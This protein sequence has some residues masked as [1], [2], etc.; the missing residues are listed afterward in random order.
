MHIDCCDPESSAQYHTDR[1]ELPLLQISRNAPCPCGSGKKYKLCC[2]R[3]DA[4]AP[5]TPSALEVSPGLVWQA[6]AV[7]LAIGFRDDLAARPVALLVTVGDIILSGEM[8]ARLGGEPEDVAAA[9]HDVVL[10]LAHGRGRLPGRVDVRHESVAAALGWRLEAHGVEVRRRVRLPEL[11]RAARGLVRKLEGSDGGP[12]LSRPNLWE[13]W[14]LDPAQ[15]GEIF[16]AAADFYGAA[17]WEMLGSG[18]AVPLTTPRGE[19]S[20]CV[21]GSAG[22]EFGLALYSEPA[23]FEAALTDADPSRRLAALRGRVLALTFD[24]QDRLPRPMR[25]EIATHHWPVAG[26]EAYPWL[27][28]FDT[29]GGGLAR[30][31]R[32]DLIAAL[33]ALARYAQAARSARRRPREWRDSASGVVIGPPFPEYDDDDDLDYL[34]DDADL[35]D[36]AELDDEPSLGDALPQAREWVR[37]AIASGASSPE[38]IQEFLRARTAG[39][40]QTPQPE[41]GGLSPEKAHRLL[42]S[43]WDGSGPL[44]LS[45]RLTAAEALRAPI[46]QRV[47][48]LLDYVTE[49]G[50][51]KATSAGNLKRADVK[52]LSARMD[53]A[54]RANY[55]VAAQYS[56]VV[57]EQDCF[58]LHRTRVLA[59]VGGLISLRKG[60][61]AVTRNGRALGSEVK[62]PALFEHLFRTYF[63]KYHIGYGTAYDAA[64]TLQYLAPMLLF[65]LRSEASDWRDAEELATDVLPPELLRRESHPA[66][67]YLGPGAMVRRACEDLI[68]RSLADF[69]LLDRRPEQDTVR[70]ERPPE[71]R[72]TPLF[73]RFLE[74]E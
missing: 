50:S 42:R 8:V 44:R 15:T 24:R 23:D 2:L 21:L 30:A 14:G 49:R 63:R 56:S 12:R 48:A 59:G 27:M 39:Y 25:R 62:A 74:F 53:D 18:Q 73:D 40:N 17:P 54:A 20:A 66:D 3:S 31:D 68:F 61:F 22:S 1:E 47:R 72:K 60:V 19:W 64:E 6:E 55:A 67:A 51:L 58:R 52:E 69:T 46:V 16:E 36:L 65:R 7:P 71:Y 33:R 45:P 43:E 38:A 26:T 70:H 5:A 41:L 10:T 37:E 32:A 29:P 34:N 4:A 13:A 35:A 57:N 11:E 28:V 9:L